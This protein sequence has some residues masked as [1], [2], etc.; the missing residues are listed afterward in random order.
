M[1]FAIIGGGGGHFG[2]TLNAAK[3]DSSL[4]LCGIAPG[5][6]ESIEKLAASVKSAG[7]NVPSY[8]TWQELLE[9]EQPDIAVLCP[10]YNLLAPLSCEML[11]RGIHV[12]SEKPCALNI[13]WLDKLIEAE[14]KSSAKY[15]AMFTYYYQPSFKKAYDIV[16]SG[17][18][19]EVRLLSTQKSYKFGS[20]RPEFYRKK[21]TYGS[22]ILWVGIHAINWIHWFA[23]AAFESTFARSTT[24]ANRGYDEM[25]MTDVVSYRL[26]GD[27]FATVTSDYLNHPSHPIHGDDRLHIA[28]TKGTIDVFPDKVVLYSDD[29]SGEVP[30]DKTDKNIF[31]EF[32]RFINGEE[33]RFSTKDCFDI[34]RA[35]IYAEQ[36]ANESREIVWHKEK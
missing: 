25:D 34:T 2:Y 17:A 32:I 29:F 16:K 21:E 14:K 27:I 22:T 6:S 23:G 19:G 28:G 8:A 12:Y 35:A 33:I 1:K 10:E 3:A 20:A 36:S 26:S 24:V 18:I 9:K 31:A 4:K 13:E 5:A 30:F 11:E 7:F 15:L